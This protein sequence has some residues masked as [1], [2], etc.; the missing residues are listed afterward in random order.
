MK[1]RNILIVMA[2]VGPLLMLSCRD[3][4]RTEPFFQELRKQVD[5]TNPPDVA[6]MDSLRA[7]RF[8]LDAMLKPIP[9]DA[10]ANDLADFYPQLLP[11]FQR[12]GQMYVLPH[13]F[14]VVALA[15]NIDVLAKAGLPVPDDKFNWNDLERYCAVLRDKGF[16]G[17]GLT[18]TMVNW[19]PFVYQAGGRLLDDGGNQMVLDGA[20]AVE[21]LDF[22]AG[23]VQRGLAVAPNPTGWPDMGY[24]Q[25]LSMFVDGKLGMVMVG[26]S[27]YNKLVG[28]FR[29]RGIDP[30]PMQVIPLARHPGTGRRTSVAYVVGYGLTREPTDASTR[31]LSYAVSPEGMKIWYNP[32]ALGLKP[33]E[34]PPIMFVPAR[35]SLADDWLKA[36]SYNLAAESAA[37]AFL[38]G[39]DDIGFYQPV[40]LS[41]GAMQQF[42]EKA[43]YILADVL[44]G[45]L[46]P[47]TAV[48]QIQAVGAELLAA[49]Q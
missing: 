7:P 47:K 5:G 10:Y 8:I 46:D 1:W 9:P 39:V 37:R 11:Y 27:P 20:P 38:A 36:N 22:Y 45:K 35:R 18:P 26:P 24:E 31:F 13:D 19:L 15:V 4:V 32:A 16:A 12:N 14:Q 41:Y 28:Q 40:T 23:L 17:I 25:L 29:S 6:Y 48:S 33:P 44:A 42:D 2:I 49:N 30:P 3:E 21:A 34:Q 43:A